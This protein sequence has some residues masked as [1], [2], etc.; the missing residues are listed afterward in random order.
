MV[1][2]GELIT[3]EMEK[4]ITQH[5]E[6]LGEAD[7]AVRDRCT[8]ALRKMGR[9]AEPALR[10]VIKTAKDAEVRARAEGLL[11]EMTNLP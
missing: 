6:K 5:I 7:P 11:K 4:E 9:F 8:A 3:P 1:G 2:R 10:R